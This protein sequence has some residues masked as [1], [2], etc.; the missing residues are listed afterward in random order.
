MNIEYTE[1]WFKEHASNITEWFNPDTFNWSFSWLISKYCSNDFDFW[2]SDKFNF[3]DIWSLV[4]YGSEHFDKWFNANNFDWEYSA[5]FLVWHCSDHFQKWWDPETFDWYCADD[6]V[7]YCS[8]YK[9]IWY[10]D[11][12]L[13]ESIK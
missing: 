2:F 11:R 7:K 5:K 9:D 1:K 12:Y 10:G 3:C 4:A 8:E 6:L 13:L